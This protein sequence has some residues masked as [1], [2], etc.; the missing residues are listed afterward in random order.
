MKQKYRKFKALVNERG[1]DDG[2][3]FTFVFEAQVLTKDK[4]YEEYH[5]WVDAWDGKGGLKQQPSGYVID[6]IGCWNKI[7]SES[8]N[9]RFIEV[10]K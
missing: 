3:D 4:I 8:F 7:G 2:G 10:I 5:K 9:K 6:D 1:L